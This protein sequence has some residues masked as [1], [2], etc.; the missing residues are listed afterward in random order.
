MFGPSVSRG[1]RVPPR[2]IQDI[3]EH[4][5]HVRELFDLPSDQGFFSLG[6]F[7]ENMTDWGITYDV[8]PAS[9]L[10][11]GV[12]ACCMPEGGVIFLSEGTYDGACKDSPRA[13]FTVIHELGH[14]ALSHARAFHRETAGF[15][16]IKP[17]EDSEWQANQFAAEFLMPMEDIRRKRL[18]APTHLVMEYQVSETAANRRLRQLKKQGVL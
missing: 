18:S 7:I 15:A 16:A 17:Y 9:M 3:R 10:P 12:E 8:V 13:R 11:D 1:F 2:S 14:L 5:M 4:A 6:E